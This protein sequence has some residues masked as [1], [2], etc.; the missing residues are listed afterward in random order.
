LFRALY[1]SVALNE[2][3]ERA[4]GEERFLSTVF[5]FNNV[6]LIFIPLKCIG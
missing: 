1:A 6:L 2:N 5:C 4:G 3:P